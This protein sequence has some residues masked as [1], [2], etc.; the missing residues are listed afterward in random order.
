[1]PNMAVKP[2]LVADFATPLIPSIV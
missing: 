2:K 1:M